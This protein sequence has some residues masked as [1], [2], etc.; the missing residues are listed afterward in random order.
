M[1]LKSGRGKRGSGSSHFVLWEELKHLKVEGAANAAAIYKR[2]DVEQEKPIEE[3]N[4]QLHIPVPSTRG[5]RK[6]LGVSTRLE[7]LARA[8]EEVLEI[9]VQLKQG[10]PLKRLSVEDVVEKFLR[11]KKSRVRG[12]WEGKDEAGHKSIT[13]ERYGLIEGKLRNYLVPFLGAKTDMRTI[14]SG[15]WMEWEEWRREQIKHGKPKATT[16]QNEMGIIRECW[17]WAMENSFIP[18]T[19]KLP[20]HDENLITDD[21]ARR[22]T[23]EAAEWK[24]FARKVREWLK[25]MEGKTPQEYWDAFVSYQM[26]FFLANSGMRTGELVKVKRKDI[27]FY[28]LKERPDEWMNGKICCLVQVHPSTKTGAREVNA[29]G[30]IFARRVWEK[31]IH[32]KKEDFLFCHL[33]GRQ[34]STKDL[35]QRFKQMTA[36][37]KEKERWGKHFVP[38]SLR[39][40]YATT[41]LQNGTSK[42]ALC[43]N[44]GVT[45]PYLRKHYSHYLTRLATADLMSMRKDIGL[46]G[47]M[48]REGDDFTLNDEMTE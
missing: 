11:H 12:N 20:F 5:K 35:W 28:E 25:S 4:Y 34:F 6:S 43:R 32:K 41:R 48:L 8:E 31:S 26:L 23:W 15:K 40:L 18:L 44:M 47:E 37:T 17:R 29:M 19:P 22:D 39:H 14:Q 1:E 7:A 9:R 24:S 42:E 30:G 46:G 13:A 2:L 3:R 10:I 38:Y 27:Q 45:E 16:I 21:K 36:Y 33:D